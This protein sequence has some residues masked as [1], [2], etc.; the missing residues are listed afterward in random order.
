MFQGL[1]KNTAKRMIHSLLESGQPPKL[2]AQYVNVATE[3]TLKR[4]RFDYLDGILKSD[5][6]RDGAGVCKWVV[7]NYGNGKTQFLRCLQSIAWELNY[8]TAFV[9]LSQDECPLDRPDRVYTAV[10]RSIQAAP[11][12][13]S[14]V[15]RGRGIEVMLQQLLD[16]LFPEVL[17]GVVDPRVKEQAITWVESSLS[18]TPI[19]CSSFRTAATKHLIAKL[20]GDLTTANLSASYLRGDQM[21]MSEYKSIG[22][23]EKLDKSSGFIFLR[24]LCQFLQRSE[25]ASGTVLLFDEARRSL[26]LMS[27][28]S[29][30]VACENLLS[31]INRCNSEELPGTMFVYAVMPDFFSDFATNYPALQQRCGPNTKIDL[32]VINN[33][34]EVDLLQKI[35]NRIA[36]VFSIAND[37]ID[38]NE[39]LVEQNC[40]VI[41]H[42]T[43]KQ[44]MG[45]GTRRLFVKTWCDVLQQSRDS[46]LYE[47][48][49]QMVERFIEGARQQL[50]AV[51]QEAVE[52]EGE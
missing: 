12:T 32:E 6:G 31:V 15:D 49:E 28:K 46:L 36:K 10:A 24:S 33:G 44:T 9:E 47:L 30:K 25:L 1:D 18:S 20:T 21:P 29:K 3:P 41:A 5:Q 27:T 14:D 51:E 13:S 23:Y 8:T 16:R 22:L 34:N 40:E 35:G 42:C 2:G 4:L 45:S 50:D 37:D 26:S 17:S 11:R 38:I 48:D 7:A 43:L 39:A 52:T 19:E